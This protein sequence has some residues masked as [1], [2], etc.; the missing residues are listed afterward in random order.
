MIL[1]SCPLLVRWQAPTMACLSSRSTRCGPSSS[2]FR[3]LPRPHPSRTTHRQTSLA[4]TAARARSASVWTSPYKAF[5]SAAGFLQ[6]IRLRQI[7]YV[8]DYYAIPLKYTAAAQCR[9]GIL[10]IFIVCYVISKIPSRQV[11]YRDL[12]RRSRYALGR[13]SPPDYRQTC[14]PSSSSFRELPRPHPSRKT[15]RQTTKILMY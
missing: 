11:P 4:A 7:A 5:V 13:L 12:S 9:K 10:M 14:G 2:S 15:H 6:P 8:T 3:E 1:Y